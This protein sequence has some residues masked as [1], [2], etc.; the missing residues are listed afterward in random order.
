MLIILTDYLHLLYNMD[1]DLYDSFTYN[2]YFFKSTHTDLFY[3]PASLQQLLLQLLISLSVP[4]ATDLDA[5]LGLHQLQF[6]LCQLQLQLP[7]LLLQSVFLLV[8]WLGGCLVSAGGRRLEGS[9][10]AE[11]V[12]AVVAAHDFTLHKHI[13]THVYVS[14]GWW[15]NTHMLQQT[16]YK[17]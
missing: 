2:I 3:C 5:A 1:L 13:N 15:V 12:P 10:G 14:R 17:C 8:Q 9:Q 4:G 16:H 6:S 7:Q 11:Q